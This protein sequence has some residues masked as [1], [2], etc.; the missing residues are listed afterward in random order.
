VVVIG[1]LVCDHCG[2]DRCDADDKADWLIVVH[3]G[4]L[5][6]VRGPRCEGRR[7]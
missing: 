2:P 3:L 5:V 6:E 1:A 4:V 7:P